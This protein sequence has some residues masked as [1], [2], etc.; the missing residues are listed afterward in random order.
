MPNAKA[1]HTTAPVFAATLSLRMKRVVIIEV[2]AFIAEVI[3][4]IDWK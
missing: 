2:T 4:S 3:A 1:E